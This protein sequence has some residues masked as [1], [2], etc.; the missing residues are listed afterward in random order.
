MTVPS[1]LARTRAFES[2]RVRSVGSPC[3]IRVELLA[4]GLD[5]HLSCQV[6]HRASGR[7]RC[8]KRRA[9]GSQYS[10]RVVALGFDG[11]C[12]YVAKPQPLGVCVADVA[13]VALVATPWTHREGVAARSAMTPCDLYRPHTGSSANVP[14]E[15]PF[16]TCYCESRGR[17]SGG[18]SPVACCGLHF[19]LP[20]VL[21]VLYSVL[22]ICVACLVVEF[23]ACTTALL[24]FWLAATCR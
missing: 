9:V 17:F 15:R 1:L 12:R 20:F 18:H 4:H 5:C 11:S 14:R 13:S 21:A 23:A 19:S 10:W 24:T 3:V 7:N 8:W 22:V 6:P 2:D 16:A